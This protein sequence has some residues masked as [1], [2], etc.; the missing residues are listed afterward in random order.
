MS[1]DL[2][3]MCNAGITLRTVK[4]TSNNHPIVDVEC[5]RKTE[6]GVCFFL[7]FLYKG[8]EQ[9]KCIKNSAGREWCETSSNYDVDKMWG[10]CG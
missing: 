8:E 10:W 4:C 1:G 7:P 3:V 2:G 9:Q 5:S 6:D